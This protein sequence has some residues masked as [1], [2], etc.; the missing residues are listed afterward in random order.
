MKN[1]AALSGGVVF[2]LGLTVSGMTDTNRILGFLDL[3][4]SWQPALLFVMGGAS[5]VSLI[6][7]RLVLR[8][9]GPLFDTQFHLPGR[10]DIDLRLITGGVL[11]GAGWGLYGYCPGPALSALVYAK[12]DTVFFVLAML[13]GMA[14]ASRLDPSPE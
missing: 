8:R 11:F 6:G 12:A 14:L 7:Y 10:A 1:I 5:L 2:G 13:A 3:F 9:A 4:G